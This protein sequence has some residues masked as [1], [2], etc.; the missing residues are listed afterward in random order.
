MN[1][2]NARLILLARKAAL[3]QLLLVKYRVDGM[4]LWWVTEAE[5]AAEGRAWEWEQDSRASCCLS[6]ACTLPVCNPCQLS[7]L[8]WCCCSLLCVWLCLV[9]VRSEKT[10]IGHGLSLSLAKCGLANPPDFRRP[11]CVSAVLLL[12]CSSRCSLRAHT[13]W[14][15]GKP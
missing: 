7:Y 1:R 8:V 11:H 9:V 6:V 4:V 3:E 12:V 5:V 2:K 14:P 15:S 13:Q 10:V